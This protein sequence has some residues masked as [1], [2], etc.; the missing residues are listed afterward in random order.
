MCSPKTG[1]DVE[2]DVKFETDEVGEVTLLSPVEEV[3]RLLYSV[4]AALDVPN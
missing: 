2:G 4:V 3:G 1:P